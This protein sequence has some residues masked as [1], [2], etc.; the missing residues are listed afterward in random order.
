MEEKAA[1]EQGRQEA[2][3][4]EIKEEAE[5][6]QKVDEALRATERAEIEAARAE[7]EAGTQVKFDKLADVFA[8]FVTTSKEHN[9]QAA[10]QGKEMRS[11]SKRQAAAGRQLASTVNAVIERASGQQAIQLTEGGNETAADADP[12]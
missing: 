5:A 3:R 9:R 6:R 8:G 1:A 12:S 10:V 4:K 11:E 2:M 7:S